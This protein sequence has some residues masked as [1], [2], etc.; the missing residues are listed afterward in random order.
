MSQFIK[1]D[2]ITGVLALGSFEEDNFDAFETTLLS[3]LQT[4]VDGGA[5]RLIVDVVRVSSVLGDNRAFIK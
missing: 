3:G 4:L 1:L 2:N 5:T